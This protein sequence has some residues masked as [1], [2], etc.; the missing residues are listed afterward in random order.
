MNTAFSDFIRNGAEEEKRTVFLD[1][2]TK[3]IDEQKKV[4]ALSK[5]K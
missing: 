2:L 3:V 1:I 5:D 4:L